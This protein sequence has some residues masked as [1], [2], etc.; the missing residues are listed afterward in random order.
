MRGSAPEGGAW[1]ID[2]EDP[3]DLAPGAAPLT[4]VELTDGAV[5][6]SSRCK[7]RWTGPDGTD[8]HHLIDPRTGAPAATPTLQA[9][10]I[11]AEGWQAEVLTKVAF[12]DPVGTHEHEDG[13]R[14]QDGA[15]HDTPLTRIARAEAGLELIE[16]LGAAALVVT[17][18]LVEPSA[19]WQR[20]ER[21]A[22]L[23]GGPARDL[24]GAPSHP[25][26]RRGALR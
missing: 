5:A 21:S 22:V 15:D 2:I 19:R 1:R 6:T 4:T 25:S 23:A 13:A 24:D 9:T 26:T 17:A 18:S 10:V 20:F 14:D 11:A 7:R 3:R 12:L 16:Q 8:R